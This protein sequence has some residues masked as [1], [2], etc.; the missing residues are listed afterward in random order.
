MRAPIRGLL[1][2]ALDR[3]IRRSLRRA[4]RRVVWVGPPP[5]LPADAPVVLYANHHSFYDGY[6]FHVL[7]GDLLQRPGTLWMHDWDRYPFFALAGVQPFPPDDPARRAATLRRTVRRMR[8]RTALALVLFPEGRLHAPDEGI[9]PI[10]DALVRRL[11]RL[12]PAAA[13]CPI[14]VHVTWHGDALPIA[15]L[16]A[17]AP[18][19]APDGKERERLE[20]LLHTLRTAPPADARTLLE[21]RAGPPDRWSFAPFRPF[22]E[23]FL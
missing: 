10:D 17:G 6:L 3:L 1:A 7:L 13:W 21:G 23:R 20:T 2:H 4:F 9:A 18:H 22:F 16:T 5:D 19:A 11:G 15:F 12:L 8:E 14:V